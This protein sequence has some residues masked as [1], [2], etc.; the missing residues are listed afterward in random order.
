MQRPHQL[1][2]LLQPPLLRRPLPRRPVL[3]LGGKLLVHL[4]VYLHHWRRSV[5]DYRRYN[6]YG[7]R[8]AHDAAI[9]LD[10]YNTTDD[11]DCWT[12]NVGSVIQPATVPAGKTAT[13]PESLA[14]PESALEV[15][16]FGA[17]MALGFLVAFDLDLAIVEIDEVEFRP[18][19]VL[20]VVALVA[21]I[22]VATSA[23]MGTDDLAWSSSQR[24][25]LRGLFVG[26][27]GLLT[28]AYFSPFGSI[29]HQRTLDLS[30]V[31]A[32]AV[33]TIVVARRHRSALLISV[34]VGVCL[35]ATVAVVE[36]TT[37]S[38]FLI[39]DQYRGRPTFLGGERR[40]TRPFSHAN[41]AAMFFGPAA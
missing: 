31:F 29:V 36:Y 35:A 22:K 8:S 2:Q 16:A 10:H 19:H 21:T 25:V 20:V 23:V 33:A 5:N 12:N 30:I 15:L 6:Y 40:L 17:L 37:T 39:G 27:L 41:I 3:R 18:H 1:P 28:A 14:R 26:E 11:N 34:G 24:L 38:G 7:R 4:Y 9:A 32:V 13:S